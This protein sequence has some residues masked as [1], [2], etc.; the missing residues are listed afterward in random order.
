MQASDIRGGGE[1]VCVGAS[2]VGER[3]ESDAF[4]LRTR[5]SRRSDTVS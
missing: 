1:E 5:S 3:K 4:L 2:T